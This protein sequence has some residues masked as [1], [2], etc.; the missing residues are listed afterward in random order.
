MRVSLLAVS[1]ILTLRSAR[2]LADNISYS[3]LGQRARARN[4]TASPADLDDNDTVV[5]TDIGFTAST[6]EPSS[7]ALLGTGLLGLAG[8]LRRK[9][10]R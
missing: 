6:P 10:A 9:F 4:F 5:F 2:L 8:A 3:K 7:I 1:D